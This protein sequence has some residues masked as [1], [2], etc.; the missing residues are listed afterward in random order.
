M[1][2]IWIVLESQTRAMS[3]IWSVFFYFTKQN[4]VYYLDHLVYL[5]L[6]ST[7]T[8]SEKTGHSK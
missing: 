2:I 6:K 1:S 8:R 5:A 4:C 7:Y 3:A